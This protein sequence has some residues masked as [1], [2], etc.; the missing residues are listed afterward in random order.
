MALV[1]RV[2]YSIRNVTGDT[3]MQATTLYEHRGLDTILQNIDMK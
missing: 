1:F 3:R 2:E